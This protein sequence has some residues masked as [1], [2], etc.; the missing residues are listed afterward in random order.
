MGGFAPNFLPQR[1]NFAPGLKKPEPGQTDQNTGGWGVPPPLGQTGASGMVP[2][3]RPQVG[4]TGTTLPPPPRF[5]GGMTGGNMLPVPPPN[6]MADM[7]QRFRD[8]GGPQP[9]PMQPGMGETGG[10]GAP[11][12]PPIP[13]QRPGMG[14]RAMDPRTRREF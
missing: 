11:P 6:P 10:F 3:P 13:M 14:R 12:P 5:R 1:P 9:M 8:V 4:E 2:P 7:A